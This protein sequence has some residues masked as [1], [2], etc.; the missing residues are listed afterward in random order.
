MEHSEAMNGVQAAGGTARH[1]ELWMRPSELSP[2][3]PSAPAALHPVSRFQTTPMDDGFPNSSLL[4]ALNP[5]LFQLQTIRTAVL[6]LLTCAAARFSASSFLLV[7]G[8]NTMLSI[9]WMSS[10]CT[11]H[12]I[13]RAANNFCSGNFAVDLILLTSSFTVETETNGACCLLSADRG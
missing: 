7:A 6:T 10:S 1:Q 4:P 9:V 11:T 5:G 2:A 3:L 12:L 13:N 8:K